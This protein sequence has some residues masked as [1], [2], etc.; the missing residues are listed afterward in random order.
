MNLVYHASAIQG[1][2]IF[3]PRPFWHAE[4]F[5]WSGR[6]WEGQ[7]PPTDT[8]VTGLVFATSRYFLPFYFAPS[9]TRRVYIAANKTANYPVGAAL[10]GV[11]PQ[12]TERILL[13]DEGSRRAL[14]DHTFSVYA[15][16]AADFRRLPNGE[17]VSDRSVTPLQETVHRDALS[18][19]VGEGIAAIFVT[20]L[21][22]TFHDLRTAGVPA[23]A[24][25]D[26]LP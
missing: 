14:E 4:N 23:D 24:Q 10:L 22:R 11:D 13:F 8:S 15:F 20:D 26:F 1:I 17:F 5:S 12:S 18:N 25:G 6:L 16:D 7:E 2:P 21:P 19:I 3:H 9:G